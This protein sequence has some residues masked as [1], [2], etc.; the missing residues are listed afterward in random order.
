VLLRG[1]RRGGEFAE[2][3]EALRIGMVAA[4]TEE[5]DSAAEELLVAAVQ[6]YAEAGDV[7]ATRTKAL[8]IKNR[9]KRAQ[10][11]R[12]AARNIKRL[13]RHCTNAGGERVRQKTRSQSSSGSSKG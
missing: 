5:D 9:E 8:M 12:G 3:D 11:V 1:W 7:D 2:A 10:A 4:D 13:R 6:V